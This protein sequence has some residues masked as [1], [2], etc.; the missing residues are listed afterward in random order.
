MKP[1]SVISLD[2]HN[3]TLVYCG[4]DDLTQ[5]LWDPLFEAGCDD[6][7]LGMR[8]GEVTLGFAREAPSFREALLSAIAD[9]EK[10]AL[11]IRLVR[12]EPI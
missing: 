12:V 4:V 7:L 8:A 9:V 10:A 1:T 5:D 2:T 3:F 6:A 11:P